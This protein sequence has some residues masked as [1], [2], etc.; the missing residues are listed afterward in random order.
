MGFKNNKQKANK[1]DISDCVIS[2]T[3]NKYIRERIKEFI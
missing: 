3:Y 1:K 2:K